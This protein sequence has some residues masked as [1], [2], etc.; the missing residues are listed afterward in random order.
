MVHEEAGG[1]GTVGDFSQKPE[2]IIDYIWLWH[3]TST[4]SFASSLSSL[5]DLLG[6]ALGLAGVMK[7]LP[8]SIDSDD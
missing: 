8:V 5:V 4:W 6:I 2:P 1:Y 3:M 7:A